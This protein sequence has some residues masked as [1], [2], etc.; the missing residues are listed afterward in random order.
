MPPSKSTPASPM[1]TTLRRP[2][3]PI[4]P[5]GPSLPST[6]STSGHSTRLTGPPGEVAVR[7]EA[8]PGPGRRS[9]AGERDRLPQGRGRLLVDPL[10]VTDE[11]VVGLDGEQPPR[12]PQPQQRR[13]AKP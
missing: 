9:P 5:P 3:A 4:N 8:A 7:A 12:R 1:I 13:D 6:R 10:T 2:L 11:H